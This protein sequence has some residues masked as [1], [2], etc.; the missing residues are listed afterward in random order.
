MKSK[1]LKLSVIASAILLSSPLAVTTAQAEISAS[2][3]VSNMYLWRG[4]DLGGNSGTAAVSGDLQ[5]SNG[6]FYTGVWASSGDSATGNEYDLFAGYGG[7]VGAFSYDVSYWSYVYP[8]SD[9]DFGDAEDLVVS[10]GYG[11]G[12][13]TVYESLSDDGAGARY[14]TLGYDLDKVSLLLGQH[15]SGTTTSI[16]AQVSY[17]YNDNLS[18]TASKFLD[19]D[20]GFDEDVQFQVAYSLDIK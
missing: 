1:N 12:A 18:F 4:I 8:S 20:L 9:I 3:A 14:I 11:A 16:H 2:A 13:L 15:D 19:D 5:Y 7:E 10:L 6:G 17:A